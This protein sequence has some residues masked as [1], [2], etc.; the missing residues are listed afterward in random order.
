MTTRARLTRSAAVLAIATVALTACASAVREG[1]IA[2]SP[3]ASPSVSA[4]ADVDP[5]PSRETDSAEPDTYQI[6]GDYQADLAAVGFEPA[7]DEF[8]YVMAKHEKWFC[9]EP[10]DLDA[11][12]SDYA[13]TILDFAENPSAGPDMIRVVVQYKCPTRILAVDEILTGL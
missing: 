7:D 13:E 2:G 6:T 9:E 12:F 10:M 3:S 11:S 1:S 4:V 5:S 8:D